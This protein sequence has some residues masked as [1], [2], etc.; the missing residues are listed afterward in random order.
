M[1]TVI[2]YVFINADGYPLGNSQ[3]TLEEAEHVARF[4]E[5]GWFYTVERDERSGTIHLRRI[6]QLGRIVT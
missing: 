5:R 2:G 6:Y 3:P 1:N 4:E